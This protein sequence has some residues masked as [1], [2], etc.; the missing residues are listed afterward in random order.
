MIPPFNEHGY[1]PSGIH[2]A[3]IEEVVSRFGSGNREREACGQSLQWLIPMCRRAGIERLVLNGSFVTDRSEPGDV[4]CVLVTGDGFTPNSD[5][6]VAM[7]AGLPYLSLQVVQT[8]EE[9]EFFAGV[10]FAS[11]RAGRAKGLIEVIL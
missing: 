4:D 5:A 1:L 9:L 8:A 7:R 10:L 11:D 6:A 3:T 2:R